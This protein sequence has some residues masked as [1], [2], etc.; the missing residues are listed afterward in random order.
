[1]KKS[2]FSHSLLFLV[3]LR[4]SRRSKMIDGFFKPKFYVK[5]KQHIETTKMRLDAIKTKRN[6]V[7]KHLRSDIAHLLGN[8]FIIIAYGRAEGLLVEQHRSSCYELIENFCETISNNLKSMLK[9]RE[10]PKECREAVPSLIY[11]AARFVDL[12]ELRNLRNLFAEKYGN[13]LD[14]WTNEEFMEMLRPKQTTNEM[15]LQL[16]QEIAKE[17][18]IECCITDTDND[19]KITYESKKDAFSIR[20]TQ[21]DHG[22]K[23]SNTKEEDYNESEGSESDITSYGS[24]DVPFDIYKQQSSSS[25]DET[26]I[27]L[28]RDAPN[29]SLSLMGSA[30]EDEEDTMRPFYHRSIPFPYL[31][32]RTETTDNILEEPSPTKQSGTEVEKETTDQ[33]YDLVVYNKPNPRSFRRRNLKR[34]P[35]GDIVERHGTETEIDGV[36]KTTTTTRQRSRTAELA[37]DPLPPA[38]ASSMPT[39]PTAPYEAK[40]DGYARAISLQP[41][42]LRMA[43]HVHPKLP[44]YDDLVARIASLRGT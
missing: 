17:F 42:M 6:A 10:C 24:K 29:R 41:V 43:S 23:N 30:S 27:D 35:R 4:R 11:A 2:S 39:E 26:T 31:K 34:T 1:M 32:P 25:E 33:N 7:E 28:Y 8:G 18:S 5:C 44:E 36:A 9:Q 40:H 22:N 37:I 20:K 12:P 14:R 38:R 21:D 16:M 13:S 3:N 19:L 15:V